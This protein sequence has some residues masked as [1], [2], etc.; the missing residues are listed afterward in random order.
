MD[1]VFAQ[2]VATLL[3]VNGAT[4]FGGYLRDLIAGEVTFAMDIDCVAPLGRWPIFLQAL[5]TL[6][7]VTVLPH[8]AN[9]YLDGDSDAKLRLD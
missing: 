7:T 3:L 4:I 6:G 8:P 9:G 5:T 2:E 1:K